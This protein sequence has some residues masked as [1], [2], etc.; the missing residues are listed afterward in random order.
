MLLRHVIGA[1][2]VAVSVYS[3]LA[4]TARAEA[5]VI[6]DPRSSLRANVV[7]AA[8]WCSPIVSVDLHA[9]QPVFEK[10]SE[11][12]QRFIGAIRAGVLYDCPTAEVIR[13]HGIANKT[14]M[15]FAYTAKASE[16]NILVVP[17]VAGVLPM[18]AAKG[19][20]PAAARELEYYETRTQ[21]FRAKLED[22]VFDARAPGDEADYLAWRID[23]LDGATLV[24]TDRREHY[25]SLAELADE[26]AHFYVDRC[27]G[28]REGTI[29]NAVSEDVSPN[30]K[31]R[32]FECFSGQAVYRTAIVTKEIDNV[33]VIFTL[34]SQ[35]LILL[36]TVLKFIT[37]KSIL[38]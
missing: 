25:R 9:T 38:Y 28:N 13:I 23:G 7:P 30:M 17:S 11:V 5:P 6:W 10:S 31:V 34:K 20:A 12:V 2:L 19:S 8:D 29:K 32:S 1:G 21:F 36:E 4:C 14:G 26:A 24:L 22:I 35:H 3:T 15:F 16:W 33:T 27:V 18:L 37:D